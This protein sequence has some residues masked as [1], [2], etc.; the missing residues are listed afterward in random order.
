VNKK[1]PLSDFLTALPALLQAISQRVLRALLALVARVAKLASDLASAV[2][3][4]F[5]RIAKWV[6]QL[7]CRLELSIVDA[8]SFVLITVW[9]LRLFALFVA[10][11]VLLAIFQ[12]WTAAVIY[13]AVLGVA[14]W[15]FYTA[16]AEEVE[17]AAKDQAPI[18]ALLNRILSWGLR[19]I[20]L[21]LTFVSAALIL[22]STPAGTGA[23]LKGQWSRM[24][25]YFANS[26]PISSD[27][28]SSTTDARALPTEGGSTGPSAHRQ[29]TPQ[30]ATNFQSALKSSAA[31]GSVVVPQSAKIDPDKVFAANRS[32]VAEALARARS[33]NNTEVEAAAKGA[34]RSYD[35]VPVISTISRDRKTARPL[36]DETKAIFAAIENDQDTS[37]YR[38]V[39]DIQRRALAAD[40]ADIEIAS[41]LAMYLIR[42]GDPE[43]AYK[44]AV[45]AMSLPR[46]SESTGRTA[47][48]STI[49]AALASR[50]DQEGA[51]NALF[52]TL[53]I[54]TDIRKRCE[55]A[56]HATRKTYGPVLRVATEAMF[57]RVRER[58][59]SDAPEC[60][61]PIAW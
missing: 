4:F 22:S 10:P 13:I 33:G 31:S 41:N 46:S 8:L 44:Y 23:Q 5:V 38:Q 59:L 54:S 3:N 52:V 21:A 35:F 9:S 61:L 43:S 27:S 49:A 42:A 17:T 1:P 26:R 39:V 12:Y 2:A 15:R 32:S 60:G 45:Y 47:D 28:S 19:A 53:A 34:A 50:G 37:R 55:A 51:A 30:A 6:W 36:N 11:V 57:Q 24:L 40:P 29:A 58:Q 25:G 20:L 7:Y 18:R 16:K 48:W 56:V 14:I